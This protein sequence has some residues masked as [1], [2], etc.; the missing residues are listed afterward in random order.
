MDLLARNMV[1]QDGNN[2]TTMSDGQAVDRVLDA[3]GWPTGKR[4]IDTSGSRIV[5][6][7]LTVEF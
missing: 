5:K 1:T 7:P 3:A 6:Y 2:R 4:T